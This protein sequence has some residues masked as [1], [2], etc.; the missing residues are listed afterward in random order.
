MKHQAMF[1]IVIMVLASGF[2]CSDSTSSERSTEN[3]TETSEENP[4]DKPEDTP[5]EKTLAMSYT[6][7]RLSQ[8]GDDPFTV[9]LTVTEDGKPLAGMMSEVSA[10]RGSLSE[11]SDNG[12]GTYTFTI[13]PDGT[14]EFPFTVTLGDI[15]LKRTALVFEGLDSSIGQPIAIPGD[16][17]NTGATRME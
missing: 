8:T 15:S 13:S 11:T 2:A 16:Y 4:E 12:D 7:K 6:I 5:E 3:Q 1:F 10:T 17:V 9:T 14:G